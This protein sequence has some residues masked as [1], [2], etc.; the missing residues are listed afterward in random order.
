[1]ADTGVEDPE[2]PAGRVG[3][4]AL[5]LQAKLTELAD[6]CLAEGLLQSLRQG[7][8][9]AEER[10]IQEISHPECSH[11][12][13]WAVDPHKGPT[14]SQQEYVTAVRLRLGAGGL[15]EPALCGNC[16]EAL[17]DTAAAH[18]LCCARGPSTKGHYKVRDEVLALARTSDSSAET[19]PEGLI[20]SQP[21]LRPADI[22]SST[23]IS[24]CLAALDVGIAAPEASGAGADCTAS[25]HRVKVARY[26]PYSTELERENVK[27]QPLVWSAFGRPHPQT[28]LV[29]ARLGNKGASRQGLPSS[30]QILRRANARIGLEIWRRAAR[31]V[32]A[33][34]PRVQD[35]DE[36]EQRDGDAVHPLGKSEPPEVIRGVA[37]ITA[38]GN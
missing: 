18:A 15:E 19:E 5:Q 22:L 12:W 17:L 31:M 2:R 21:T 7:G 28:T 38:A 4:S 14:L 34:L 8:R 33:C 24:G 9:W 37:A 20:A 16:G 29:L 27:Y 13:L 25:M 35:D 26:A 1:V 11:D 30:A 23:A 36:A 3:S 10:R 32:M 6:D